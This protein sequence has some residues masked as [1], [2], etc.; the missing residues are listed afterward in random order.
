MLL[1]LELISLLLLFGII[2]V[3][4][5]C[6]LDVLLIV[7]FCFCVGNELGENEKGFPIVSINC[8]EVTVELLLED[9]VTGEC[10]IKEFGDGDDNNEIEFALSTAKM[11]P[12]TKEKYNK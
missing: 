9:I 6:P 3:I 1:L 7:I 10:E 5:D 11:K 4:G 12:N 8:G 2:S